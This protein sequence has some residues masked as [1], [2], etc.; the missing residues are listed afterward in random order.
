[1]SSQ[2][3]TPGSAGRAGIRAP[4]R[5]L[6][7]GWTLALAGLLASPVLWLLNDGLLSVTDALVRY[8]MV[9]GGC[10]AMT[11]VVRGIWP[12]LSGQPPRTGLEDTPPAPA[13]EPERAEQ[14]A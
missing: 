5:G 12:V 10:V 4:R 1:M 6:V 14:E 2:T 8:L 9:L 13:D 3:S 11:V 7:D